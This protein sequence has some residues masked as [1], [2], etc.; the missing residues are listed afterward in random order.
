MGNTPMVMDYDDDDDDGR[1]YKVRMFERVRV[2]VCVCVFGRCV[3]TV[4]DFFA[5]AF[6]HE[7]IRISERTNQRTTSKML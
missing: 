1:T 6:L 7:L 3:S 2:C 4:I 5:R